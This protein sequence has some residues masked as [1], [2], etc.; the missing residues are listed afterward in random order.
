MIDFAGKPDRT[1]RR[2]WSLETMTIFVSTFAEPKA[3]LLAADPACAASMT[4]FKTKPT[5]A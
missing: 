5:T 2:S 1:R 4:A 3:A